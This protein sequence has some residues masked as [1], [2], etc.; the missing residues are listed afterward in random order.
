[1]SK[2]ASEASNLQ[3]RV[4]QLEAALQGFVDL[5]NVD[6]NT[7]LIHLEL[8]GVPAFRPI[9]QSMRDKLGTLF[10]LLFNAR[11]LLART[12]LREPDALAKANDLLGALKGALKAGKRR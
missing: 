4:E 11:A 1:M 10:T 5:L 6:Y 9:E 7:H 12:A 3:D 2:G 8:D